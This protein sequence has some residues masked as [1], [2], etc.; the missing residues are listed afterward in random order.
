MPRAPEQHVRYQNMAKQKTAAELL[1]ELESD[2]EYKRKKK[3]QANKIE[4]LNVE[5]SK[6]EKRLVSELNK[7]LIQIECRVDSV[8]DLV[9]SVNSYQVVYQILNKH[10]DLEH[11]K[12]IREGII[13]ALTV[14]DVGKNIKENFIRHFK[15]ET[16]P[17]LKWLISNALKTIMSPKE[18]ANYPDFLETYNGM[19]NTE[20][21]H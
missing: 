17:E 10:L 3:S 18:L 7:S 16:D 15:G 20:Q 1:K 2:P 11:H 8:W 19:N 12:R 13:R 14:K 9:N 21:K 6:D 4:W 5:L